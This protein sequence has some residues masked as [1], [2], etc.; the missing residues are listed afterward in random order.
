MFLI[1]YICQKDT[2]LLDMFP[3]LYGKG[4]Q[5]YSAGMILCVFHG[6]LPSSHQKQ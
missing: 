5:H 3:L 2:I 1:L 4:Q 6:A